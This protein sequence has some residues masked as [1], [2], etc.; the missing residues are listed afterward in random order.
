MA[1]KTAFYRNV[2]E[3]EFGMGDEVTPENI[4]EELNCAACKEELQDVMDA[5][6]D[7]DISYQSAEMQIS[8]IIDN[9]KEV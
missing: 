2:Y 7:G 8:E 9:M 6:H 4:I 3:L 5:L 1:K